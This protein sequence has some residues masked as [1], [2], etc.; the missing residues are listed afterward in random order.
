MSQM[1]MRANAMCDRIL[2]YH[3]LQGIV[4]LALL[5]HFIHYIGFQPRLAIYP[6]ERVYPPQYTPEGMTV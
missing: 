1:M 5:F 2:L 3:L 6:G 4:I